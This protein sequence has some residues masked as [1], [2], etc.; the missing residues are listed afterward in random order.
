MATDSYVIFLGAACG[1]D[2]VLHEV[3]MTSACIILTNASQIDTK[4]A[5]VV[6]RHT[7]APS[8]SF[9]PCH[10]QSCWLRPRRAKLSWM[11]ETMQ[12]K[13]TTSSHAHETTKCQAPSVRGADE[14]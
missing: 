1:F 10:S 5:K 11:T 8:C 7:P 3:L 6:P 4:R 2:H 9:C 12:S 13:P 14:T